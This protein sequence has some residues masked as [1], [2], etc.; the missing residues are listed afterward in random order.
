MKKIAF[1][2]ALIVLAAQ[3]VFSQNINWNNFQEG[4]S[5]MV[6]LNMGLD[7]GFTAA[8]GYGYKLNVNRPI[9]LNIE[10]SSPL[11][12]NL[13]DDFKTKLGGQIEVGKIRN[14]HAAAKVYGIFRRYQSNLATLTNFGSEFAATIGYYKRKW[15]VAGEFGFDKAVITNIKNSS[16]MKEN[17][18][19]IK[20]GWYIPAGGNFF[21]DLQGG[22]SFGSSDV[23]LS[24]GKTVAQDLNTTATLP[25]YFR[26]GFDRKF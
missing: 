12:K 20:D 1:S 21:Y 19:G 14:F 7:Y 22:Y 17:Y 3:S 23:F 2:I 5:H 18:P 9:L 26:I 11:G 13:V 10:Y 8:V 16:V 4:H 24:I 25:I 6:N 15:Y